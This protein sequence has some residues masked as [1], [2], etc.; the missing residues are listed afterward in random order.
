MFLLTCFAHVS[1]NQ[2]VLLCSVPLFCDAE[3]PFGSFEP[4]KQSCIGSKL[5]QS[6]KHF[7]L[8]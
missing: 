2:N 3:V 1:V 6:M 4:I 5:F 8:V 7:Y